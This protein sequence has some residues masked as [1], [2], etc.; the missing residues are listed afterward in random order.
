MEMEQNEVIIIEDNDDHAELIARALKNKQ[1]EIRISRL[2]DG[3]QAICYLDMIKAEKKFFPKMI[4]LDLKLP[5]QDGIAVLSYIK[6]SACLCVIPVIIFS[7][8]DEY[9]DIRN[10]Y[11]H[12]ANSYL[13]KP[14][15]FE[16]LQHAIN[17]ASD[18]W[19]D[20][21]RLV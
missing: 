19:L 8:S 14:M 7:S 1:P 13:V 21:N 2:C 6:D 15:D 16:K 17:E 18:Y 10:A 12:H 11:K 20:L 4:L 3:E 9:R 5:K